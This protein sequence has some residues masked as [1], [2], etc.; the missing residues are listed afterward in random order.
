MITTLKCNK[1]LRTIDRPTNKSGL[2]FFSRCIITDQCRGTLSLVGY[3]PRTIRGQITS[4]SDY[5][6]WVQNNQLYTHNQDIESA[7]WR[8]KHNLNT[9][10]SVMVY[11]SDNNPIYENYDKSKDGSKFILNIIDNNT[12]ELIFSAV[13]SGSAQCLT[14]SS[15]KPTSIT[16]EEFI[17]CSVNGDLVL[18]VHQHRF[19][20]NFGYMP[21]L[22]LSNSIDIDPVLLTNQIP[23]Q[24][25]SGSNSIWNDITSIV[26][27][28][29]IYNVYYFNI[30]L[31]SL[32]IISKLQSAGDS[33]C[34]I[35]LSN[36]YQNKILDKVINLSDLKFDNNYIKYNELFVSSKIS[37]PFV[38]NRLI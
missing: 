21:D 3:K 20:K 7:T 28:G 25:I 31:Q 15:S 16:Q 8:I 9:V 10:P 12:V 1:C 27:S 22:Y 24:D 38:Y 6:D 26:M 5:D 37:K 11:D 29:N 32:D 18:C 4:P 36:G 34:Y 23:L 13:I 33:N 14:R 19:D 2:D 30:S 17:Q 35:L